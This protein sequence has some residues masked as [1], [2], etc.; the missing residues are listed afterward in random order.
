M[1]LEDY[2]G[3]SGNTLPQNCAPMIKGYIDFSNGTTQ[4]NMA[5]N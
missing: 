3:A 1:R 5:A 4:Q 2:L